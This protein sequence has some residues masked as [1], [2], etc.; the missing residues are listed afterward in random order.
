MSRSNLYGTLF[1]V[2]VLCLP[3][4]AI[5]VQWNITHFAN[6]GVFNHKMVDGELVDH[7]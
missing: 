4:M 7:I 5:Y 3:S 1:L 6:D 2:K